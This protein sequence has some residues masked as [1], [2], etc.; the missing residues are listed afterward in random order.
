MNTKK[1][2]HPLAKFVLTA[3]MITV[4]FIG[5]RTFSGKAEQEEG[6]YRSEAV[7]IADLSSSISATGTLGATATVEV[8]TQVSGTLQ[9]VEVDFNDTVQPG[10]VIARIDPS[11]FQARVSQAQAALASAQANLAEA[12]ANAINAQ[13]DFTRKAQL[14]ERQLVSRTDRDMAAAQ[15][16]QAQARVLSAQA[17]IQQQAANLNS[18]KLDLAKTIIR[19][20]VKGTVLARNVEPG[21][22]V[23]ASLQ[24]PVLFKIAGDL[25]EM[26]IV[27]A[28][29]ESDIGQLQ[30]GQEATFTVDA[31]PDRNFRG[32]VKQIRLAANNVSN[33]ITFPVVI[34]VRNSDQ[35]LLPGLTATAQI[36]TSQKNQVLTV[37]NAALRF[38]PASA[39]KANAGPGFGA[40][41]S[42]NTGPSM[43]DRQKRMKSQLD[44]MRAF[45]KQIKAEP[46]VLQTFERSAEAYNARMAEMMQRFAQGGGQSQGQ[47]SGTSMGT[48][49][50]APGGGNGGRR[51]AERFAKAFEDVRAALSPEQQAQWDQQIQAL[52]NAKRATV[53]VLEKGEPVAVEIRL[54]ATDGSRSEVIG[55]LS[56]GQMVIVGSARTSP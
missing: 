40:P 2:L 49:Q 12:R 28:I 9:T 15:R 53:Y 51:F 14:A 42:A 21:Q 4:L 18:A 44:A 34:E 47:G 32:K 13:S 1:S 11:T 41:T 36:I 22:T 39:A 27:L 17:Q 7:T 25:A 24:T 35:V 30:V 20:P 52:F 38:R 8:G 46:G 6:S 56:N 19:S 26:E 16:D 43:E 3:A 37:P 31:F 5:Y 33:V 23:A 10:Q 45:L 50:G 54:G 55:G 48:G 29:D